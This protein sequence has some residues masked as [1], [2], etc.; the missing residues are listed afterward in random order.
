MLKRIR[1]AL[2]SVL[3]LTM[4]ASLVLTPVSAPLASPA[5]RAAAG[6]NAAQPNADGPVTVSDP[7]TPVET[8]AVRDA[9]LAE[10]EFFLD[11]EINPRLSMNPDFDP[12][13][14]GVGGLD[15]LLAVQAG[16]PSSMA[17]DFTTPILNFAGQGYTFVN[18]PD[19]VGDVGTNHYI[20]MINGGSGALLMI[21]DKA[22][23]VVS[24]PIALDTLGIGGACASG[25]GDPVVLYDEMADRWL[26]S[27]FASGGNHLCVYISQTNNPT[28]AYWRYDFITP[29]FPDYPKY[30]VWPDA[31]YVTSNEN[32][33]AAYALDRTSMLAGAAATMQRFTAPPISGFGFQALTPADLDGITQPAAGTPNF[34]MRHRDTEVHGPAG[35]PSQDILEIWQFHVDWVTPANSF[36]TKLPDILVTEFDSDLCGLFSFSCFNQP[37]TGV[38]LDPLREVIMFRLQYRNFGAYETLV[39]NLVTD[40]D[41]TDHGGVRWFELRRSGGDWALYQE[42]TYAPDIHSRWMAGISMDVSGNIAMGY[43][44]SSS[45]QFPSLRYVGRLATDPL[46]TMPQGEVVLAAGSGSNGSNRYGDYSAM[47]VDPVDGCTFWFTGMYNVSSQWSTRIGAFKFDSCANS[48]IADLQVEKTGEPAMVAPGG[49]ITYTLT[50]TNNGPDEAALIGVDTQ[51]NATSITI[52]AAGPATPYPSMI[53]VPALGPVVDVNVTLV[54]LSHT[55]PDDIDM[56]VVGPGGQNSYLMSDA[57]GSTDISNVTL[58]F[59]DAAASGLPDAAVITAGSYQPTNFGTP[60]AFP[61]PAPAGPYGTLLSAFN[62]TDPSGNWSLYVVDAFSPDGGSIS[63][64]W[65]LEISYMAPAFAMVDTLPTGF[66]LTGSTVPGGW[67]CDVVGQVIT[68]SSPTMPVGQAVVEVYG[69]A[70]ASSGYITNTV[71]IIP[72]IIDPDITN[73]TAEF[74]ILVNTAPL[75]ADDS[76]STDEDTV[77]NVAAPGVMGNDSDPDGNP[78]TAALVSGVSN[79]TLAFN[80]DGSFT[81]T[82]DAN[83]NGPDQFSYSVSDGFQTAMATALL[84]VAAVDDAPVAEADA[85]STPEDTLLS[86]AAPGPLA[87]DTDLEGDTLSAAL[88]AAPAH[89]DLTLNGD[90]SFTYMPA[91]NYSG[92]DTFTYTVSDGTLTDMAAVVI[93]IGPINDAPMA[94]AGADQTVLEG[95]VV[96]FDGSFIDPGLLLAGETIA[97][98]FGD[99]ASMTGTLTPAHTYVDN[100]VFTVTLTV[101][102]TDGAVGTDWLVV[103]VD[104]AAPVLDAFADQTLVEGETLDISGALSDAGILDTQTVVVEWEAG[105]TET[106]DLAAGATSFQASHLFATAGTYT[107]TVT[108]TDKDGGMAVQTFEVTV[109]PSVWEFFL[110]VISN[111]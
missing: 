79:G 21:Y 20:Q 7:V 69:T 103:T 55:W 107:V 39:G 28:G 41:G 45:S 106:L 42:G 101:T 89:G 98:D 22:G 65:S 77:L 23:N 33:P 8:I 104:N 94:D 111:Q 81:Y 32:S 48:V 40:V 60:D 17:D 63:G 14:Q 92:Q 102:D 26:L 87:N 3:S 85:Y 100:G 95:E 105:A 80:A 56:I 9:P 30:A 36:F 38:Q 49:N 47:S 109:N 34:I 82:P 31:Y 52:P 29:N 74:A 71:E 59:D 50:A 10:P 18:P 12:T 1:K 73:N 11:R 83:Y 51:T 46:G 58:T 76:Y 75:A 37:G 53:N 90:G 54:N 6:S 110:P 15:P 27:E 66:T 88:F 61:A 84:D 72:A 99:G 24:G 2:I 57:G 70:P 97:W 78:L 5:Q 25:L 67:T 16:A 68:C 86:V 43:N 91:L 62:G 35:F 4:L 44:V 108:V 13:L 96:T 93:T 19:T 64:G